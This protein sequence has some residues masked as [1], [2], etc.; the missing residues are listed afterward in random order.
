[1]TNYGALVQRVKQ[2]IKS[3]SGMPGKGKLIYGGS[4][5]PHWDAAP[6]HDGA[7]YEEDGRIVAIDEYGALRKR[8]PDAP[9]IG[10][11]DYVVIP[12]FVNA[13]A[14]GRGFTTYQ[15]GQPDE[16]L[17]MRIIEM[18]T[19]PEWGATS[20]AAQPRS[21]YDPYRDTLY[22]CLKQI[23]SGITSTLHS[24]IYVGGRVEPY[25]KLTREVLR[26][27]AD[28]GLRCAFAL[29]VRDRY[30][31]TFMDDH[32]FIRLLPEEL[33]AASG[34]RPI[35][36]DMGFAEFY[37]LLRTLAAE[38]PQIKFQLGPWNPV[39]CSD[40]LMEQLAEASARDGWR[41]HTH[42]SETRYQA[43]YA[44]KA[45]GKS[46][47]GR[48]KELGMLSER[49]SGAHAIWVDRADI[50]LIKESGAQIVHNP[51]SNL[52]LG[53]G[54]A[55]VRDLLDRGVPVA[56]GLDSLSMNDDEDMFQDL[57]LG[58]VVQNRPGLDTPP[59]AA[60]TMFTMATSVGANVT[61]IEG[62]GSLAPGM[63]ADA[64]LVSLPEVAG[65]HA[66]QPLA[67]L[68]LRRAKAAHVRTVIIGGKVML[69][70]GRW[71]GIDP[72]SLRAQLRATMGTARRSEARSVAEV[73]QVVRNVLKSYDQA[74]S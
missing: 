33:R 5:V 21:S 9:S 60:S 73:K 54:M 28:S 2:R 31:F 65:G 15:M 67:D 61:G 36:C 6:I 49:F 18:A 13:H 14:H 40:R 68:M 46:W 17:E 48:L 58:Q 10:S 62:T 24:H 45:Y 64:V 44:R 43:G 16:P 30:S 56:F 35:S 8:F 4:L 38:Y 52:R 20:A 39:W 63:L 47:A 7:L 55:P 53:S 22:A 23:A 19:R 1:L 72:E 66:D 3:E 71:N 74:P 70:D 41:I 11:R 25:A 29:G 37:S 32:E 59:L 51:S 27:Y 69:E 50:E 12:G 26:A 42:L 34:I 57:R